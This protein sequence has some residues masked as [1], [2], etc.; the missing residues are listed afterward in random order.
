MF[1]SNSNSK[2]K[3]DKIE[4]FS[5]FKRN[6]PQN[7]VVG[8][9]VNEKDEGQEVGDGEVEKVNRPIYWPEQGDDIRTPKIKGVVKTHETVPEL[10]TGT[11]ASRTARGKSRAPRRA[12]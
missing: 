5:E 9:V 7:I 11:G 2:E 12:P 8:G 10:R 6:R 4:W 3:K 1:R